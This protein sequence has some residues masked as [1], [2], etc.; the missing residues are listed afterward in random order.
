MLLAWEGCPDRARCPIAASS[1]ATARRLRRCPCL[2]RLPRRPTHAWRDARAQPAAPPQ[3]ELPNLAEAHAS[4]RQIAFASALP[5]RRGRHA[6][7]P[8]FGYLEPRATQ[9]LPCPA[10]TR[11]RT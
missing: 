8:A 5:P 3:A 9:A 4:F 2:G 10:D 7:R 1:V 11:R 6:D